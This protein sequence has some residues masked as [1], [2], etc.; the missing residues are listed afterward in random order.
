MAAPAPPVETSVAGEPATD[1]PGFVGGPCSY[2]EQ[3]IDAHVIVVEDDMVELAGTDSESFYMP[4]ES[5]PSAPEAGAD[6]T[7]KAELITE[8]TCTP[9]IYTVIEGDVGGVE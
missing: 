9:E 4:V 3:M 2:E 5:F 1:D 7:I 6:Y 8:G